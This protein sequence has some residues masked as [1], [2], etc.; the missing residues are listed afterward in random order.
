[1]K[2]VDRSDY[3]ADRIQRLFSGIPFFNEV[4]RSEPSQFDRLMELCELLEADPGDTVIREGDSDSCLY[5]LLRGQLAVMAG[6]GGSNGQP[7][8]YISP[9]EVFGTLA[10]IRGT[11]RTATICV[12][13]NA[14]EAVLAKLDYL[15]FND[16]GDFSVLTMAT[17]LGFYRMVVHNIRWTLEVNKMQDPGNPLVSEL[18]KV[19]LYTGSKGGEEELKAL[20]EQAHGLADLLC[21]WNE[22]PQQSSSVQ[23]T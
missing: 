21:R 15:H 7:L 11:P 13:D 1:M 20:H 2:Q 10:M 5:F 16:I 22:M 8:N 23:V 3:P 9:G 6:N 19:P 17:K 18:R 12:D 14:R 4:L